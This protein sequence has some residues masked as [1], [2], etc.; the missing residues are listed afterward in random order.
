MAGTETRFCAN[1]GERISVRSR[2]CPS[3]GAR[4]E[5]FRVSDPDVEAEPVAV[6]EP[7]AAEEPR[8]Q[9]AEPDAGPEPPAAEELRAQEAEPDAVPEPPAAEELRARDAEPEAPAPA[10]PPPAQPPRAEPAASAQAPR[11]E[12]LRE[13]IGRVDPQAGE[14]SELLVG[15]LAV[16]GVVA[17]G[18]AALAAAGAVLVAGLIIALATPDA[19]I[20]GL[21]GRGGG[22]VSEAFRQ[23]V[24]TLLAPVIDT[25]PLSS[26]S[27]RIAPMIFVAIPIGAVALATRWQ[28]HRTEGARPAARIAWAA[29]VGLP[30]GLLM[31]AFAV[32][33]GNSDVANVSPS[34]GSAFALGLLW[35]IV[36][37][38]LGAATAI[39][40]EGAAEGR[41]LPAPLG[42]A[43]TAG[44]ATLRPLGVLLIACSALGLVGWIVQVGADVD[45]VRA[46]RSTAT[47]L[48]EESLF[49]GEHGV[50]LAALAS[51]ARFTA[52]A[53]GALGLPFPV[54]QA[55][56][57]PGR[58]GG[59][60]VFSYTDAMPAYVFLPALVLLFALLILAALYA[61]F[62]AA[63]AVGAATPVL[64]AAWGAVTGPAWAIAM[65]I[66]ISLAGG[67]FH[68]D[69]DGGSVFGLFL[70]LG[71]LL[72]AGGGVLAVND[73]R[74]PATRAAPSAP[75]AG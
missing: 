14:L 72:G 73:A 23:A 50:H 10:D 70:L 26:A 8:A 66:L 29:V 53:N 2:F 69:A 12:P 1:C 20:L 27:G 24:S 35:G 39:P 59:L 40:L 47:A 51:G 9:E 36:G 15:H 57:V 32:L 71:A 54:D 62:A 37:G 60:R 31:L 55:G 25:G 22:V 65:S 58:D 7:P 56:D 74:E 38:A 19:S 16:P 43:L 28:L 61:G 18:L 44:T 30:F 67:L 41:K 5:D 4:Q 13:R 68:G 11:T 3:C 46:G 52:D 17:A 6:P 48:V 49:V 33:G 64:G 63:R 42:R 75:D 21:V 34:A 45:E